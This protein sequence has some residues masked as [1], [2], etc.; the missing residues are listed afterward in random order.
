MVVQLC[1]VKYLA[2]YASA[3][4]MLSGCPSG[5]PLTPISRDA[6]SL[7]LLEGFTGVVLG[8]QSPSSEQRQLPIWPPLISLYKLVIT[9]GE[10]CALTGTA[11]IDQ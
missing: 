8:R 9:N 7:Q 11:D 6:I 10:G 1:C 5:R 4:T 2:L 3:N